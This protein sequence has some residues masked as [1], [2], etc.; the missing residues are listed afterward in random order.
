MTIRAHDPE[1]MPNTQGVLGNSRI[2]YHEDGYEAMKGA[3]GLVIFTDW[4][5]FRVPDFD[6]M[7]KNLKK[8]VVF[9]G[10]NLYEPAFMQRMGFEYHSVGRPSTNHA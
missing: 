9:D 10:R 6:L 2:S 7:K 8:P 4:Q 3:D 5:E 1:A